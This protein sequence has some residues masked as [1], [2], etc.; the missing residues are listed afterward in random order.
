M[1]TPATSV[2]PA[3]P[4][5][6]I[7][8]QRVFTCGHSFHAWVAPILLDLANAAGIQN[9]QI[10]GQAMVG[11][12]AGTP[13]Y[14][15]HHWNMPD[16]QNPVKQALKTGEV[17]V[18]TLSPIW[19]P[20]PAIE[21]FT[22]LGLAHNPK[23]RVIVQAFWLPNDEFD[24][25][26][27]LPTRKEVNHNDTDLAKLHKAHLPYFK[28]VDD[29]VNEVNAKLA[30][31]NRSDKFTRPAVFVA[32][33]G[34]AVLALRDKLSQ[35]QAPGLVEPWDL[36]HDCWGH[37]LQAI[38]LL[39]AYCHFAMIYQRSPVGL[40]LP[41]DEA[42]PKP[43]PAKRPW[44]NEQLNQL[45]QELALAAVRDHPLGGWQQRG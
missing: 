27:P 12:S 44:R 32:P 42:M 36:F 9:H 35:G 11:G 15:T 30:L 37:P 22:Q 34:Q 17:D 31:Q 41:S 21:K 10:A 24:P 5:T 13:P 4:A 18:L 43:W 26:Y 39:T 45:L 8:G 1:N 2:T 33:V 16:D 7:P 28:S 25:V 14:L 40:P 38:Q 20:D 23:I 29:N 3:K 19:L 6:P